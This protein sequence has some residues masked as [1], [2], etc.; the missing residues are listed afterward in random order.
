M[1]L[2]SRFLV[3][4]VYFLFLPAGTSFPIMGLSLGNFP[5]TQAGLQSDQRWQFNSWGDGE[6]PLRYDDRGNLEG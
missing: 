3:F 2:V 1:V 6:D 4:K 5:P